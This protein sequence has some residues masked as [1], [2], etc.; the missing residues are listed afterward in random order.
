MDRTTGNTFDKGMAAWNEYQQAPW[1]K[2]RY[3][4]AKAN[5]NCHLPPL[6]A[7]ILDLGGGNG[8]D[9]VTLVKQGYTVTVVDFSVEM[10]AQGRELASREG[11]SDR[12]TFKKVDALLNLQQAL[13][14]LGKTTHF[15]EGFGVNI[16]RY[17]DDE[18]VQMLQTAGFTIVQRYGIRC[19]NDYIANNDLKTDPEF[20]QQL[21]ALEL[22]LSDKYP[23]YVL[24]R[25]YH[26]I[27][28]KDG[29]LNS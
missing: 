28:R 22:A 20:Y 4:V 7:Q 13:A 16:Q 6:P 24:A 8:F 1:G 17:T 19:V 29:R 26:L 9:A 2:L 3:R 15:V 12:I 21:E 18:L 5:L 25:F 10:P 14:D 11:V 27:A 23:F